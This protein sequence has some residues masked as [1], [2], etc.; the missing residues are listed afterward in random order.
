M[1]AQKLEVVSMIKIG[2]VWVRQEELSRE[3]LRE[4]LEKK[5]DTAMKHIGFDRIPAA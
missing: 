2:G 4:I 1:K 5:L 3:E